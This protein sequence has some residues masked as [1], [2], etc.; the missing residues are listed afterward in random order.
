MIPLIVLL[1]LFSVSVVVAVILLRKAGG[2][3]FPWIQF[4][5]KGKESGFNFRELNLLRKVAVQNHLKNPTSLFWSIK[6][7]EH[8]IKG[9]II[10]L[11]SEGREHDEPHVG[12]ITKLFDFR[13]RV[14][15]D[16]P[17][18]KL[19]L[20]S[21]RKLP[22]HQRMKITLPGIGV[23]NAQIVENLRKY[24]A[25]SYP[26]GPTL[27]LD[28]SWKQQKINVYFWRIDDAG[29]VFETKVLEDFKD[30]DY[31]I[32]HIQHSDSLV[33]SQKRRSIRID[34]NKPAK[35][36]AL[37]TAQAA[38]DEVETDPGLR[39][40]L[41]DVSEDDAAVLVG[42]KAKVGLVVKIQFA[43]TSEQLVLSG[44]VKGITFDQKKN[45]SLLHIQALPVSGKI[46]NRILS[47]V[48]N[49]FQEREP[50]SAGAARR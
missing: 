18:Y 24:L 15:F 8:S 14:E 45:Q 47:Y 44:V 40:R 37:S 16:L 4:Y 11:R 46:K 6:Q 30:Q 9:V 12:F 28:F 19:G 7:L 29:Y 3:K 36:Y 39:C 34:V 43:L 22:T 23:Y 49:L 27:P 20:K 2:G 17:K 25:I 35:L 13:K 50:A 41:L 48:Y 38:N 32:L 31:P 1:S 33:R 5:T 26:E 42:G 21:T 10:T